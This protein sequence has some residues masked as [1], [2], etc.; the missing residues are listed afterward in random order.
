MSI[1]QNTTH[2]ACLILDDSVTE[3]MAGLKFFVTIDNF[4][5]SLRDHFKRKI[6]STNQQYVGKLDSN[7]SLLG[8][9][10]AG[11]HEFFRVRSVMCGAKLFKVSC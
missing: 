5:M 3:A 4:I 10:L 2:Q 8:D 9:D 11:V 7:M 6:I 1:L